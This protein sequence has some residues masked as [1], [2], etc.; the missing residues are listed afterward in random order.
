LE[1]GDRTIGMGEGGP[2]MGEDLC[3]GLVPGIGRQQGRRAQ[4]G[5][6][7]ADLAL[8]QAKAFPD[9]LPGPF[10]E[11]AVRGADGRDDGAGGGDLEEAPQQAGG[12][13]EPSDFVGAPDADG[14]AATLASI[15]ITAKDP[16]GA[17][18]FS[19][20]GGVVIAA[21]IAVANERADDLA[22]RTGRQ[23]EPLRQGVP[24]LVV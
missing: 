3:R 23:L 7:G 8:A 22:V 21:Q 9:A 6:C 17:D 13:A 5:K 15:A 12:Q 2:E 24:F 20:W 16:A 19:P 14:S 10:A 11:M 4:P 18:R 1:G